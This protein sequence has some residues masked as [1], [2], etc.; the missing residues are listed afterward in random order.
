MKQQEVFN[1]IGG[2][3]KEINEQYE[4][5]KQ[6]GVKYNDVELELLVANAH[7][8]SDHLEILRKVNAQAVPTPAPVAGKPAETA[9]P[10]VESTYFE[11]VASE[12]HTIEFEMGNKAETIRHEL[13][14]EGLGDDWDEIDELEHQGEQIP[15]PIAD[16]V[17]EPV[18]KKPEP[19]A[20]SP[21]TTHSQILVPEDHVLTLNDRMSAQM[22]P[23]RMSDQLNAQPITDLKTAITLNDKL[24]YIKDLFHGYSL[25][26]S[27]AIDILNK[28]NTFEEAESFLKTNYAT[29]NNWADKQ[30][31]ADK[32]YA[33]LQRRYA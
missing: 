27:E 15:P 31:A 22:A 11:P 9:Q 5:L 2:I 6:L 12:D 25:A 23:G 32:F 16:V 30:A 26:Y 29:K 10:K 19:K 13:G 14:M 28:F 18:S 3:I 7:F 20:P 33:L 1:K 8:L 4:D 17:V 21:E 24:L